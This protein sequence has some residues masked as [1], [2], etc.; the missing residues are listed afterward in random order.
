M[1]KEEYKIRIDIWKA[2]SYF[3]LDTELDNTD[4]E[5]ISNTLM[6]SNLDLD[7]LKTIDL[8]EVFPTLQMNLLSPAG[9]W[10]G[11]DSTWLNDK[12]MSNYEKRIRS[13]IFRMKTEL[14]NKV[15][16]RM[17]KRHW[18]EIEKRIKSAT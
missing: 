6:K 13:K 8:Y 12:C 15:H 4:Y 7:E 3:Y 2:I 14:R 9:E 17:R 16:Y 18:Q 5:Y 11:F 1:T 10:A